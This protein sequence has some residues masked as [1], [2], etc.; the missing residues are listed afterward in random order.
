MAHIQF[1]NH[2]SILVSDNKN[3]ILTDPWYSGS[4]FNN[5]WKLLHETS[6]D[7]IKKIL[8]Q[9]SHIWISHEHPDHFSPPFFLKYQKMIIDKKIKILFQHTKDKRVINFLKSKNFDTIEIEDN[10]NFIINENFSIR[11]QN[12]DFYDSSLILKIGDKTIINTNDCPFENQSELDD[13]A[14][15]YGPADIL[16]TQFSYAAWKGGKDNVEWRRKAALE[17]LFKIEKQAIALNCNKIIPFASFVYF[18]NNENKYL[19]DEMNSPSNLEEFF[20][21]KDQEI[22]FMKPQ[23][24]CEI[25]KI[26]TNRES[27]YFWKEKIENVNLLT[28]FDYEKEL[29]IEELSKKFDQYRERIFNKNS[30]ILIKLISIFPFLKAFRDINIK[31]HDNDNIINVSIFKGLSLCDGNLY[32]VQM[33][34]ES[35][36][37]ILDNEFGFDTLTVNGNFECQNTGF[38]KIAK[39]L[40]LGSLNAMGI[41]IS[42]NFI[43]RPDIYLLF[44]Q[45]LFRAQKNILSE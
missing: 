21:N 35:F 25:D 26:S 24:K 10:S 38:S 5:G 7:E 22:V 28:F 12:I 16:L 15:K 2:A 37:F 14:K 31:L 39:L 44:I 20:K 9:V 11:I 13:F 32:D 19:N 8:N 6:E 18:S 43:F 3:G 4:I 42:I 40:S 23:E 30:Y 34:S 33:H 36:A 27:S 1:I 41:N 17:K 45:K 29:S